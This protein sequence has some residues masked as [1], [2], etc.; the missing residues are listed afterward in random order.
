[1]KP[2]TAAQNRKVF[3]LCKQLN[4]SGDDRR[5]LIKSVTNKGSLRDLTID[6]A[7]A[8]IE[9]LEA[10]LDPKGFE[11][12]LSSGAAM[13]EKQRLK[14]IRIQI[15]LKMSSNYLQNFIDK[16]LKKP[17]ALAALTAAEARI[18]IT[19]L[20]KMRQWQTQ[21]SMIAA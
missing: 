7:G 12:A 14:I 8:V 16:Q 18:V 6:E 11:K 10:I 5:H 1:M 15:D 17:R 2:I 21:K 19:G 20:E 9:R 3:A 13:T 4:M